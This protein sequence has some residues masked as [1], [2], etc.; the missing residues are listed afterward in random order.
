[1][2][3]LAEVLKFDIT[4]SGTKAVTLD[5]KFGSDAK[6]G[7]L[8]T[9]GS[10]N[11]TATQ[12]EWENSFGV[13]SSAGQMAIS[14]NY[15]S[16]GGS[17]TSYRGITDSSVIRCYDGSVVEEVDFT[18][19][20]TNVLNLNVATFTAS[21]TVKALILGG[22]DVEDTDFITKSFS[23]TIGTQDVTGTSFT[24][25]F[26][27]GIS[28]FTGGAF[29]PPLKDVASAAGSIGWFTDAEQLQQ[30]VLGLSNISTTDTASVLNSGVVLGQPKNTVTTTQDWHQ[31][32][33]FDSWLSNGLRVDVTHMQ[34]NIPAVFFFAKFK[35]VPKLGTQTSPASTTTQ[36]Y[37]PGDNP[38]AVFYFSGGRSITASNAV[39]E[40]DHWEQT[41]GASDGVN[42]EMI[43]VWAEDNI[44]DADGYVDSDAKSVAHW[45]RT[46][47]A[48]DEEATTSIAGGTVTDD[49]NPG[50]T[51]Q[52]NYG[53]VSFGEAVADPSPR[54]THIKQAVN[55]AGVY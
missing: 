9:E 44:A 53:Y 50:D 19:F 16:T 13:C 31:K 5:S 6:I 43:S 23:T 55:R 37:T 14:N 15:K 20:G 24:P 2:A 36:D 46:T 35:T 48:I 38:K 4:A 54:S 27:I 45:D 30:F 17:S 42:D 18:S 3:L 12:R 26:G 51:N 33:D 11:T 21:Y 7:I 29:P 1:M 41:L 34:W 39:T 32:L 28:G 47:D 49:W 8:W 25:N 22:D 52:R 10:T 40:Y